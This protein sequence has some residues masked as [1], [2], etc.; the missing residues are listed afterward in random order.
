MRQRSPETL[1]VRL[2]RYLAGAGVAS[3][4]ASE[5]LIVAGRVR[6]NGRIVRELGTKVEP[7]DRVELDG[8]RIE[9]LEPSRRE[10]VVLNKPAGVVTTMHDPQ[11]RRTVADLVRAHRGPAAPRLVPVGRL[12]YDTSGVLLLTND[13]E[14][15]FA[16]THPRFGVDKVYRAT[17]R[18]R[19]E[20]DAVER[21]RSGVELEEGRAAPARLRVVAS[22]RARSVVDLTLH[23]GRYRQVRRMFEALGHPLVALTRLRFGPVSLGALAPGA[24]RSLSERERKALDALL[25][26]SQDDGGARD[27]WSDPSRARRTGGDSRRNRGTAPRNPRAQ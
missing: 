7:G 15:A 8:E 6:V 14:L 24:L 25:R 19:L 9:P 10:V 1:T 4:R 16:L 11:G 13:G 20:S 17:L 23:E 5:A 12:D 18:G 22:S 27:P 26:S 3:R 2:Q 21:I